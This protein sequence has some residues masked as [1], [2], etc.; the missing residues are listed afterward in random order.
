MSRV[1]PEIPTP[2]EL[3]VL[4]FVYANGPSLVND[5]WKNEP[6]DK[7]R[8]YTS[9]MSL[10]SVMHEKGILERKTEGRA[11][12]YSAKVSQ[13]EMRKRILSYAL[14]HGFAGSISDL[15]K[16]LLEIGKFSEADLDAAKEFCDQIKPRG[17]GR[18]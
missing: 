2:T 12:R 9:I 13:A 16:T 18:R 17:K 7:R 10:M 8:A 6:R 4:N 1:N 11:Y 5:V 15:L 14:Q 3:V